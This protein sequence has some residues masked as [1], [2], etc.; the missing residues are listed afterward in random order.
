MKI[1][2]VGGGLVGDRV[3]APACTIAATTVTLACRDPAQ[4]RAIAETG[5]NPRHLPRVDLDGVAA[6]T[7]ADGAARARPSSSWWPC[8]AAPSPRRPRAARRRA[9]LEPDEGPRSSDGERALDARRDRPVAVLSR[10]ELRRGGRARPARSRRDRERG[11][12]AFA[13]RLQEADQLARLPR[14]RQPRPDRRRACAAAKNVIALAAGGFDGLGLG[15]N[16]K[17][18]LI[19]RGLVGDGP[20]GRGLRRAPG[21]LLRPGRDGRPDR[22]LLESARP[23]PPRRRADRAGRP[24]EEAAGR[25]RPGGRGADDRAGRCATSSHRVGIELP[26]TEGVCSVLEGVEPAAISSSALMGRQPDRRVAMLLRCASPRRPLVALCVL[27]RARLRRLRRRRVGDGGLVGAAPTSCRR[28]RRVRLVNTDLDIGAVASS[29]RRCWQVPGRRPGCSSSCR[30][31]SRTRARCERRRHSR[32]SGPTTRLRLARLRRTSDNVV[33]FTKP[34]TR[35]SST[36]CSEAATSHY[37]TP[38]IDGWTIFSDNRGGARPRSAKRATTATRSPR[39]TPST[40]R[41]ATFPRTR[42]LKLY[43][44]GPQVRTRQ[45]TLQTQGAPTGGRPAAT[46]RGLRRR[47]SRAEDDGVGFEAVV[48]DRRRVEPKPY[49]ADLLGPRAGGRSSTS[50]SA[51]RTAERG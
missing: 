40:T 31:A 49:E 25:D 38:E 24:P 37:S 8:R 29:A 15:D 35:P 50:R 39:R 48:D 43:L 16:A 20:P 13:E 7:I 14:L 4:V 42:S 34:R 27:G 51:A 32:R 26:I 28:T 3:R 47:G 36:R 11:R 1:A 45:A 23:Q 6:A 41:W 17:A 2:V 30:T 12:R 21:D 10:P 19:T 33:G 22:D 18:A 5:R 44:D 46:A 9:V